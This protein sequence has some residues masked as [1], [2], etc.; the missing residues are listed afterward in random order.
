MARLLL[1]LRHVP[2]DEADEIR[3][4]LERHGHAFFETPPSRWGISMGAIWL[5]D[6]DDLAQVQALLARYQAERAQRAR[7]ELAEARRE[8]RAETLLQRLRREPLR[9]FLLLAAAG[10]VLYLTLAPFLGF[11]GR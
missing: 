1:N 10:F 4:L 9:V 7:A 8:G 2:D 3:A 5:R 6:D 11:G